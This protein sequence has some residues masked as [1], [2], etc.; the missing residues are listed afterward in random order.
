[1]NDTHRPTHAVVPYAT[2]NAR[3]IQAASTTATGFLIAIGLALIPILID[4]LRAG[5]FN[6]TALVALASAVGIASLGVA[7]SYL[8]KLQQARGSDVPPTVLPDG[9]APLARTPPDWVS[10]ATGIGSVMTLPALPVV[11]PELLVALVEEALRE[12]LRPKRSPTGQ[13]AKR[14]APLDP[15]ADH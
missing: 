12:H 13:F 9:A 6:R 2:P 15:L 4:F 1:M 10:G 11:D 14:P 5:S 8:V 3:A 7:L